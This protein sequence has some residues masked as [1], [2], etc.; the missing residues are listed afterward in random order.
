MT[1]VDRVF[2]EDVAYTLRLLRKCVDRFWM[3]PVVQ[4]AARVVLAPGERKRQ[5]ARA[6]ERESESKRER[7]SERDKEGRVTYIT[8]RISHV[9]MAPLRVVMAKRTQ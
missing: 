5:G 3:P 7:E 6:R 9:V 4:L 1:A 2:A 8:C